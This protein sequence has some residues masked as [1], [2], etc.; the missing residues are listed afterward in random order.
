MYCKQCLASTRVFGTCICC[1]PKPGEAVT[2]PTLRW[3][4]DTLANE[5][6]YSLSQDQCIL[7][8]QAAKGN[9]LDGHLLEKA[10]VEATRAA[11]YAASP[12]ANAVGRF[13]GEPPKG[14]WEGLVECVSVKELD[15][16]PQYGR[17][18]L[19]IFETRDPG[20]GDDDPATLAWFTGEGGCFD[21]QV[22]E[23]YLIRAT[24]AR[25]NVY[26]GVKQSVIQRPKELEDED[27]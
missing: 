16:H 2:N 20:P 18:F 6:E 26:N 14:K 17:R 23:Y 22:G 8:Q 21:P 27:G 7:I 5:P 24:V 11:E 15:P 25:H 13:V 3:F 4:L 9:L 12:E 1:A 10:R 19:F